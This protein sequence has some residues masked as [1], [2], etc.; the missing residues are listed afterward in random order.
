MAGPLVG[1][2]I[3]VILVFR[4]FYSGPLLER[5][6]YS[7]SFTGGFYEGGLNM[8]ARL[9]VAFIRVI[10]FIYKIILYGKGFT[11]GSP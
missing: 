2:F 5:S 10:S 8:A 11:L 9:V 6:Q 4:V 3:R 7:G 1:A